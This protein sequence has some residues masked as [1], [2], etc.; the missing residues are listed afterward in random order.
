MRKLPIF[1][2]RPVLCA[3]LILPNAR[4]GGHDCELKPV[5]QGGFE[6]LAAA[7]RRY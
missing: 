2:M 3:I 7:G 1:I 5:Y 4:P 6:H